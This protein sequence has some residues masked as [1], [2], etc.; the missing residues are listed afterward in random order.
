MSELV[1]LWCSHTDQM[2]LLV[3]L[4]VLTF[5]LS[6]EVCL[7]YIYDAASSI[8]LHFQSLFLPCC[9]L[10]TPAVFLSFFFFSIF[11]MWLLVCVCLCVCHIWAHIREVC[12][13]VRTSRHANY[14]WVFK[15]YRLWEGSC[16]I[17]KL[18]TAIWLWHW[19]QHFLHQHL[20]F[21]LIICFGKHGITSNHLQHVVMQ[22]VEK[23]VGVS[24]HCKQCKHLDNAL[25]VLCTSVTSAPTTHSDTL[26][27]SPEHVF[28]HHQRQVST[29]FD[30]LDARLSS[31]SQHLC[32]LKHINIQQIA[33]NSN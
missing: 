16:D 21:L 1:G 10:F 31:A 3:P 18:Q 19:G 28:K 33:K 32:S 8:S 9:F 15:V 30:F 29:L 2:L 13:D 17:Q 4:I 14:T 25:A 5:R 20:L 11:I 24:F 27:P 12:P 22:Q 23:N 7:T 26:F 6:L